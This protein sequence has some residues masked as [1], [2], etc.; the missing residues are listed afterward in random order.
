MTTS[1][2][3]PLILAFVLL[4]G[5]IVAFAFMGERAVPVFILAVANVLFRLVTRRW[6]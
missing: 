4:A 3:W 1:R 6:R 2:N 5:S